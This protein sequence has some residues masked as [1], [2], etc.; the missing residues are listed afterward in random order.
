M[1]DYV[2]VK[3]V[4]LKITAENRKEAA[5]YASQWEGETCKVSTDGLNIEWDGKS[6]RVRIDDA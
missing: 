1:K 3:E 4:R 5:K 2:V 6:K